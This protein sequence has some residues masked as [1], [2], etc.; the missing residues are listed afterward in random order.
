MASGD[1]APTWS[2]MPKSFIKFVQ[3]NPTLT[4]SGGKA[5]WTIGASVHGI[6]AED[7]MVQLF[8]V[9]TGEQVFAD[10]VVGSDKSVKISMNASASVVANTYK[11][12]LFG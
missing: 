7:I 6:V 9:A 8:E 4:P 11:A 3:K 1:G 5:T 2:A 12:V 10:V